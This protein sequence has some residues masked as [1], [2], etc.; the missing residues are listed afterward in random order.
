MKSV[1]KLIIILLLPC[2]AQ[3]GVVKTI[4]FYPSDRTPQADIATILDTKMKEAQD[5]FA[6]I[7]DVHGYSKKTFPL[8]TKADG[9]VS[10]SHVRGNFPDAYYLNDPFGKVVD[11]LDDNFTSSDDIYFIAIDISNEVLDV[12][13]RGT[14]VEACGVASGNWSA[15]PAHGGCFTTEVIVH[16]LAHNFGLDHNSNGNIVYDNCSAA[17]LDRH[18][19]FNGG[20]TDSGQM[21]I[22][23]LPAQLSPNPGK[24]RFSF[25][26]SDPDELFIVRFFV[27]EIDTVVNC[28]LLSETKSSGTLHLDTSYIP[29]DDLSASITLMDTQGNYTSHIFDLNTAELLRQTNINL[30]DSNLAAIIR[31]QLSLSPGTQITDQD[32]AALTSLDLTDTSRQ[33][34]NLTGL[35]YAL[36]LETLTIQG[37]TALTDYSPLR[38]LSAL[39]ALQITNSDLTDISFLS[40]LKNLQHLILSGN[41]IQDISALSGLTSLTTLDLQNNQI[42]DVNPLL[43]LTKLD[44]LWIDGNPIANPTLLKTLQQQNPNMTLHYIFVISNPTPNTETPVEESNP[45]VEESEPATEDDEPT[46]EDHEPTTEDDDPIIERGEPTFDEGESTV[47]WVLEKSD[48][49]TNIGRP[50]SATDPDGDTLT[51]TLSGHTD[52]FFIDSN[53][54]QLSTK[55]ILHYN[56]QSSYDVNVSVTDNQGGSD[57]ITVTIRVAPTGTDIPMPDLIPIY[58][59]FSELMFTS[60]GGLHSLAQWIEL[61]NHSTTETINMTGWQLSIEA[62]DLNGTH[63]NAI[64]SFKDFEIRPTETGLIVTWPARQKS[65]ALTESRVYN[66]FNH[67]FEEFEQ[68]Q[69]R[70]MVIGLVGFSLQLRNPAGFLVDYIGNLDGDP[71]TKDEP[72]WEMPAGTNASG[73]RTSLM[74]RYASE[75]LLPL[76]GT[77]LNSW[78]RTADLPSLAVSTY[79]GRATDIGNPGYRGSG[80]LPVTL[81][82]FRADLTEISALLSWT[83]ESEVDNAG[84]NILRCET[85]DGVFRPVNTKLIQGSSTT[86]KR[87]IYSWTDTTIRPNT[88]YYYRIEDVSYSGV[89]QVSESVGLRGL[90]R[91]R[92]RDLT[93]WATIKRR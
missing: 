23:I 62:R 32:I 75:T 21:Q 49:G 87:T 52:L 64:I 92:D 53:T 38:S 36:N 29:Q 12:N 91:P 9:N 48:I 69:H 74:R 47:R 15:T 24:V 2:L 83:T 31:K 66:F 56:T 6:A 70:N 40:S 44:T 28:T 68:N 16:E 14:D 71:S 67:H 10:V 65:N 8:D 25:R 77:D 84:F 27:Y 63:R 13:L 33:I 81:S 39:T 22:E 17:W 42:T 1:L 60:R 88:R 19:F 20:N 51:Y 30:P 93:S 85:R 41:A 57:S 73:T 86:S 26:F 46:T 4:Y 45:I 89:L 90:V 78:R 37:Q 79:W 7:L 61:F 76:D 80:T 82:A 43:A 11:E 3:A 72:I 54:G 59:S 5:S 55:E 58:V 34:R 50:I 35:E 18:P